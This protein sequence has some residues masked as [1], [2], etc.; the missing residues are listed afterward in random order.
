L[1][2]IWNQCRCKSADESLDFLFDEVQFFS[3]DGRRHD[4]ITAMVLKVP[5]DSGGGAIE[6]PARPS[7]V[8]GFYVLYSGDRIG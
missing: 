6:T 4:D 1:S 3:A 8:S 5:T 7:N 2:E